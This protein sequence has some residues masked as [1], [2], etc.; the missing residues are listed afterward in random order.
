M[1]LEVVPFMD[2]DG[3]SAG[4]LETEIDDRMMEK[5]VLVPEMS[6][7]GYMTSAAC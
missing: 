5:F 1:L 2:R 7:I 3:C 6:P 4:W